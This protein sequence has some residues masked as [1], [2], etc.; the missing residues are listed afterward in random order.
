MK[1]GVRRSTSSS[2]WQKAGSKVKV[3]RS[4]E[5]NRSPGGTIAFEGDTLGSG[6]SFFAVNNA[7]GEGPELHTHPYPETWL[8][9]SGQVRL[10]AG[11]ETLEAGPGDIVVVE[12][13]MPHGFKNI[14]TERLD[15]LCLHSSPRFIQEWLED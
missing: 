14:G 4:H 7:P 1:V 6:V 10:T 5:I 11:S 12:A 8:V 13:N 3:L 15:I 2:P 9:R